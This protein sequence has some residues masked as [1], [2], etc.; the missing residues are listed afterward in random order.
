M[1]DAPTKKRKARRE[2]NDAR[3]AW[4]KMTPQERAEFIAWCTDQDFEIAEV[5]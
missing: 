1:T 2:P 4:R 3:T 5:K